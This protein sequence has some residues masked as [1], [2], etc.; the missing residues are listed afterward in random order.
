MYLYISRRVFYV[1]LEVSGQ[2]R[3]GLTK[4]EP[5][6]YVGA[7][8]KLIFFSDVG[9]WWTIAR[10]PLTCVYGNGMQFWQHPTFDSRSVSVI[11]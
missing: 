3:A 5:V 1:E 2:R 11:L 8:P 9:S 7:P 10:V 4:E 6:A